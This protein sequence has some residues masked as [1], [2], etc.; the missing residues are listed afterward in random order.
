MNNIFTY[1]EIILKIEEIEEIEEIKVKQ[2]KNQ[3]QNQI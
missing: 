1:M 3:N 2:V